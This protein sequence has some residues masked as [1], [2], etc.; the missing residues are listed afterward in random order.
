MGGAYLDSLCTRLYGDGVGFRLGSVVLFG[1]QLSSLKQ[2]E[3]KTKQTK[4]KKKPKNK[5]KTSSSKAKSVS[6]L[7]GWHGR[8]GGEGE[9]GGALAFRS[10][11]GI[12]PHPPKKPEWIYCIPLI[13]CSRF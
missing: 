1:F 3:K 6:R 12:Q 9:H 10:L 5:N 2:N 7:A 13:F 4:K 11:E 8:V